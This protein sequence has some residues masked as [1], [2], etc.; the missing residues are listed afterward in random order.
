MPRAICHSP[1]T[2]DKRFTLRDD[3][4]EE[5]S[6]STASFE[7]CPE[8]EP[9]NAFQT[10]DKV[11]AD[12]FLAEAQAITTGTLPSATEMQ[13]V[14]KQNSD[15]WSAPSTFEVK[16]LCRGR[17][18]R[19]SWVQRWFDTFLRRKPQPPSETNTSNEGPRQPESSLAPVP[20]RLQPETTEDGLAP[21][22]GPRLFG[23]VRTT[24]AKITSLKTTNE[25][26]YK[27][28]AELYA[29]YGEVEEP[30]QE[31]GLENI[32]TSA[33]THSSAGSARNQASDDMNELQC[34]FCKLYFNPDQNLRDLDNGRSPCSFHPG[35]MRS[36]HTRAMETH[37][38]NNLIGEPR[39][40]VASAPIA[41]DSRPAWTCCHRL[42]PEDEF[43]AGPRKTPGCVS[44]YH[45]GIEKPVWCHMCHLLFTHSEECVHYEA[46]AC[47]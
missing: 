27:N 4:S 20:S 30:R 38:S 6:S 28:L 12:L 42:I 2:S 34:R 14:K 43:L 40:G 33:V 21:G 41:I 17:D 45:D 16:D 24:S 26:G 36:K 22:F 32:E 23:K 8:A 5:E 25:L 19:T 37:G 7:T 29:R 11:V 31:S 9:A 13:L 18:K 47:G 3:D 39:Q 1:T 15:D 10:K 46:T 44:A 35:K